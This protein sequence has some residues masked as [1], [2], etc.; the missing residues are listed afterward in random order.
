MELVHF[1]ISPSWW[2][3]SKEQWPLTFTQL[4][5]FIIRTFT[6]FYRMADLHQQEQKVP[7][8]SNLQLS[9]DIRRTFTF[10]TGWHINKN[11]GS[12]IKSNLHVSIG[13]RRTFNFFLDDTSA[14]T[15]SP[16]LK[17]KFSYQSTPRG[18]SPFSPDVSSI[19]RDSPNR[20]RNICLQHLLLALGIVANY[21]IKFVRPIICTDI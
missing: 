15:E 4:L 5:I 10:F 6:F 1:I 7:I 3:T 16:N 21:V 14:K 8:K 18:H 11:R 13:I 12:P 19:K 9:I 2:S 17:T 20:K